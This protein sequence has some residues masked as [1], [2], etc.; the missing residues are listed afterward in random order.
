[1]TAPPPRPK[2]GLSLY[3]NLADPNE[4]NATISSAPVIYGQNDRAGATSAEAAAAS[5]KLLDP[6]L[7]FQPI[8]RPQAK[9]VAKPKGIFPKTAVKPPA[10]EAAAPPEPAAVLP[11]V[12]AP[13]VAGKPTLADWAAMEEDEW[14]YGTA[15]E[16]RQRGGRKRKKRRQDAQ[17]ETDWDEIYDPARPTNVDEYLKSD[18]KVNEVREWRGLLYRHRRGSRDSASSDE[19]EERPSFSSER[20]PGQL[21]Y[22]GQT[23]NNYLLPEQISSL[24]PPRTMPSPHR[25]L[26][27]QPLC[28]TTSPTMT[29]TYPT[30]RAT[31]AS[32][33]RPL[34]LKSTQTQLLYLERRCGI[35]N[36]QRTHTMSTTL[37]MKTWKI[38]LC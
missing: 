36:H 24:L 11:S 37:M 22:T 16:K 29:W 12:P 23:T 31:Q 17:A 15:A 21:I 38:A 3:D 10:A 34:R 20:T 5:K 26:H 7:R 6:A 25:P 13:A 19:E 28:L 33:Q 1:M 14:R 18:E 27:H 30:W 2:S 4:S 35:H 32:S 9:Q 8:R